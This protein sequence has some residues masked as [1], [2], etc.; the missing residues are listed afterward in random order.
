MPARSAIEQLRIIKRWLSKSDFSVEPRFAMYNIMLCSMRSTFVHAREGRTIGVE[1]L[2]KLNAAIG[3]GMDLNDLQMHESPLADG[4]QVGQPGQ[5]ADD[6][7][8][9]AAASP[10]SSHLPNRGEGQKDLTPLDACCEP[11]WHLSRCMLVFGLV[12]SDEKCTQATMQWST[13]SMD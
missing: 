13:P 5:R 3:S 11:Q 9:G 1:A 12:V 4:A 10:A 2:N 6:A 7:A 8:N